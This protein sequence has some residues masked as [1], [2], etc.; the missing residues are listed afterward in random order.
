MLFINICCY[1]QLSLSTVK[2]D[3]DKIDDVEKMMA[4]YKRDL[5]DISLNN[6]ALRQ[7]TEAILKESKDLF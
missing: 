5:I 3:M 6:P 7:R 2:L 1:F 4:D